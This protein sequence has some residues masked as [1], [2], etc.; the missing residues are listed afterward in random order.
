MSEKLSKLPD[1]LVG[2]DPREGVEELR[3]Y[4]VAIV[5][6]SHDAI[7][8]KTLDGTITS[9]NRGAERLFGY[10]A[11]EM[12]GKSVT[13]LIPEDRQNE[14]PT[15]IARLRRGETIDHYETVRRRKDGSLVDISLTVSPIRDSRGK[16]IGASKIARDITDRRRLIEQQNL[17]LGE[18][19]H[20]VK[21]LAAVIDGL[22]R[23]SQPPGD[24]AVAAFV[25]VF[26]GRI[27]ALLSTGELV[28]TS[29]SRQADLRQVLEQV[30]R[31]FV[32]PAKPSPVTLDGPP[33]PLPEHT[34][35]ALALAI[36]ELATNALKYGALKAADG[37]ISVG[38]S[39]Q[40][41][42]EGRRVRLEWK[43]TGGPPLSAPPKRQG[44]G[45][46]VIGSAVSREPGGKSEVVFEPDGLLCR[47]EFIAS[48]RL[49]LAPEDGGEN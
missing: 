48:A 1:A 31:P 16:V 17:M 14:E 28:V 25:T 27:H 35:G 9:W 38:W 22:A 12:I 41:V 10:S 3:Q 46:R 18:M 36:H 11:E 2:G 19:Q 39:V 29:S 33:L 34:A 42:A 49:E 40:S 23:Q 44:F 26:L 20:R 5:E 13:L 6:S 24:P 45:S 30:L 15:I 8:S 32:D 7:L 43:E 37:R 21:N 47:F 4:L